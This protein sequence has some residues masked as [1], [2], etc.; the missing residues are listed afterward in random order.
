MKTKQVL[1]LTAD[2]GFGHRRAAQA[3]EL[4]LM[5]LYDDRCTVEI[6]NPLDEADA[7]EI[8]QQLEEGYDE[9]VVEDPALYRLAYH[10]LDAPVVSNLAKEV[11]ALLLN[12]VVLRVVKQRR[13]DVIVSTYPTYSQPIAR[14]LRK[15]KRDVPLA[16]VVTDLT[17]VQRFWYS[18]SATMHFLPTPETRE[19][20][21]KNDIP[22]TRVKVTGLPVSPAFTREQ[23]PPAELRELL[24]W[25]QRLPTALVVASIRTRQMATISQILDRSGIELQLVVVCGG[26]EEMYES[27]HAAPWHGPVHLYEWV[28]NMPQFMKAADFTITKAGGLVVSEALASSLPMI[29]PEALP[30]QEM[31]NV[32]YV[33]GHGVGAW[34]PGPAEVL[35]TVHSWLKGPDP[36]LHRI[37]ERAKELGKPRAAYDI[38][39]GVWGLA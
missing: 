22:A 39:E 31:G 32:K 19:Q 2:A 15:T 13:P 1:L 17:D 18:K 9:F 38:A 5:E 33:V 10:A 14:A 8:I 28:E 24:G 34:A 27:L 11:A 7:P 25:D 12:D 36:E 21:Y 23:R 20:A 3:I 26:D 6:V 37:R 4:A 35:V 16:V 29:I 30:G